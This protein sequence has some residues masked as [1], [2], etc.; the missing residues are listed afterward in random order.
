[1]AQVEMV[2]SL[3]IHRTKLIYPLLQFFCCPSTPEVFGLP[4]HLCLI[5]VALFVADPHCLRNDSWLIVSSWNFIIKWVPKKRFFAGFETF[6]KT[7]PKLPRKTQQVFTSLKKRF[8]AVSS[9][10]TWNPGQKYCCWN[11]SGDHQLR[12]VV[13]PIIYNKVLYI[14]GGA[15]FLN[16]QQ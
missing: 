2:K 12:L 15:G 16:H 7:I 11:K 1:M 8:N 9:T 3:T 13:D 6:F 10:W 5:F 14:P 4:W